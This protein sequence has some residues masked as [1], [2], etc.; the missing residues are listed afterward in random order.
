MHRR[1]RLRTC[2]QEKAAEGMGTCSRRFCLAYDLSSSSERR[3]SLPSLPTASLTSLVCR[4]RDWWPGRARSGGSGR[5]AHWNAP[6]ARPCTGAVE[7]KEVMDRR[8][9]GE[10]MVGRAASIRPLPSAEAARAVA[11]DGFACW[12]RWR[13]CSRRAHWYAWSRASI[14]A[15]WWSSRT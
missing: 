12:L 9:R 11:V 3:E 13:R 2:A 8:L 6:G 10:G 5:G 15:V 1:R 4:L 14:R 7:A